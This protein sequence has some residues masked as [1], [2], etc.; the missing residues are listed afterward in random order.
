MPDTVLAQVADGRDVTLSGFQTAWRQVKPPERPDSLTPE[1]AR[2]FLDLLI[3]KE[4]LAEAAMRESWV[5]TEK[6]SAE[7]I[8]TRD[9]MTMKVVLDSAMAQMR[10][11]LAASMRAG[12][13]PAD[14]VSPMMLGVAC[15]ESTAAALG[16]RFDT[17]M[18][19]R[20]TRAFAAIP[21]P[22]R[23]SSIFGQ[24][25]MINVMPKVDEADFPLP[26]AMTRAGPYTVNEVMAAWKA[27][28]P[29]YRP[30]VEATEQMQDI[31]E[32][33]LFEREL[34]RA[35]ERRGIA[36][37]AHV[38]ETLARRAEYFAVSHL[39]GREVYDKIKMDSTTLFRYY[40]ANR[41]HWDLPFRV[42]IARFVMANRE[43]GMAVARELADP[44]KAD[45]LLARGTRAGAG[46][47]MEVSA[48]SDSA[49][50]AKAMRTGPG[51]VMGPD[52]VM[53]GWEV[54]RVLAVQPSR[55]R[56]F[57]ECRTLVEHRWYGTE[58][59]RLMVDLLARCRRQTRVVVN[60]KAVHR[61]TSS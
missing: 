9:G 26:V 52:S 30:R 43:A 20:M 8:A 27:L 34:R 18:V 46:Y 4:A 11:R 50:F 48:E 1:N 6:E 60:E 25:R 32:N 7:Y 59:E 3:E 58:G 41:S 21:K 35:V 5:W 23:D 45:S 17:A 31:I 42:Q 16:V 51:N 19:S 53:T 47:R 24:L 29:V 37:Q 57:Q 10:S 44:V 33:Q 12:G 61:L 28:S 40:T 49:L 54:L 36:S 14:T 38:V 15:R 2:K 56:T 22:S 13:P 39:V 55:P